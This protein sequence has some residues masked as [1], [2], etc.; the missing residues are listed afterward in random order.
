[1]GVGA[2]SKQLADKQ[3]KQIQGTLEVAGLVEA[4][5]NTVMTWISV[6]FNSVE[7]TLTIPYQALGDS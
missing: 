2:S 6:D 4:K 1:M 7:M 5:H 3:F